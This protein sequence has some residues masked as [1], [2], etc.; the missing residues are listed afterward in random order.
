MAQLGDNFPQFAAFDEAEQSRTAPP[1]RQMAGAAQLWKKG[2][3]GSTCGAEPLFERVR[4]SSNCSHVK[5]QHCGSAPDGAHD[6]PS[7]GAGQTHP[8]VAH[9]IAAV[10]IAERCASAQHLGGHYALMGML[11]DSVAGGSNDRHLCLDV[12]LHGPR[13]RRRP[14]LIESRSAPG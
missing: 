9:S 12:R 3:N 11:K 2:R 6:A 5:P 7:K 13:A 1:K 4:F 14:G 10:A 8:T